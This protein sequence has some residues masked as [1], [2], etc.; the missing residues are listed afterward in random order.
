MAQ[1]RLRQMT[2][3]EFTTY[4]AQLIPSYA[5][6]HVQAGDWNP[7]EAET[8]AARQVDDLLPA[9]P[10]TAGMLML[11]AE[12]AESEQ[13]G[14]VWIALNR[15]RPGSA[16]IYRIETSSAQRGKGYGRALLQAAEEQ[17]RQHGSSTIGL[18]VFGANTVARKLYDSSGYEA[19]SLVMRK[20]LGDDPTAES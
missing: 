19:T 20:Q 11:T 2:A 8:L 17:A 15:S 16:W 3:E 4:R 12:T 1:I 18:H 7:E 6:G 13:V 9:G 14:M 5:A 10:Q